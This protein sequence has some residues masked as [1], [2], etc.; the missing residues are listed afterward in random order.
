MHTP[1]RR[2]FLKQSAVAGSIAGMTAGVSRRAAAAND[3]LVVAIM[4]CGGRS[5]Q[6]TPFIAKRPDVKIKYLCDVDQRA[7]PQIAAIV[8]EATGQI[9]KRVADFRRVLD[10]PEVDALFVATPMHWHGLA[11]VMACQAGKH[12]Y[13]E[14]PISMDI[15]EGRKMVE[16]ARK[17]NRIVQV[18]LQ[19]RSE[20]YLYR[21]LEYIQSG[22][23]GTLHSAQFLDMVYRR[24]IREAK[25]G[26]V[27]DGLDYDMYCGPAPM[28]PYVEGAGVSG[29]WPRLSRWDYTDGRLW[30]S[31]I[32]TL[33]LTRMLVGRG[34]PRSVQCD[35]DVLLKQ[36]GPEIPDT[37]F[38]TWH[39]DGF[40][41]NF[42]ASSNTP[43]FKQS[44]SE[45]SGWRKDVTIDYDKFPNWL[46]EATHSEIYGS[47]GMMVIGRYGGGWQVWGKDGELL[48]S[49]KG[50]GHQTKE[51]IDNFFSCIRT[52]DRPNADIEES[53]ISQS[54]AHMCTISYRLGGRHLRFDGKTETF[55]DDPD[56][57][58]LL[59]REY[60]EPWV[61]PDEV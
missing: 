15:W 34:Y 23:L 44:N 7:F 6:L 16:A 22:E 11:T 28:F 57:N 46:L 45:L 51:H 35:A 20:D 32:H 39:Y 47:K 31:A 55:P 48:A 12:V 10:D 37:M 24:K 29:K 33:D 49:D 59:R 36:E 38:V 8:D 56:A 53:H 26:P 52:G 19:P 54:M 41:L 58:K 3:T 61:I 21:A 43:A 13:V 17:Y 30:D 14:K 27:P 18:G 42:K 60:R 25:L 5:K 1:N 2:D 4:G 9:P 50:R 40:L